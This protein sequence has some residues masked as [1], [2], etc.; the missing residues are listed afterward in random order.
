MRECNLKATVLK[1]GWRRTV[2]IKRRAGASSHSPEVQIPL[3]QRLP[4]L[5]PTAPWLLLFTRPQP[6]VEA[7]AK[8]RALQ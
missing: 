8:P 4:N 7:E 2:G 6:H 1:V 3:K 5:I